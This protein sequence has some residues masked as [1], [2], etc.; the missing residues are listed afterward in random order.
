MAKDGDF[1][2]P[3]CRKFLNVNSQVIRLHVP[4]LEILSI[5]ER[6]RLRELLKDLKSSY[7]D[8][9]LSHLTAL[10]MLHQKTVDHLTHP[11]NMSRKT[12]SKRMPE[13]LAGLNCDL[14]TERLTE[15]ERGLRESNHRLDSIISEIVHPDKTIEFDMSSYLV[16]AVIKSGVK[17]TSCSKCSS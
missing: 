13:L 6:P 11:L 10:Q 7:I 17:Q 3:L 2:C 9:V 15:L 14:V 5:P 8:R 16:R 1:K 4:S 12:I